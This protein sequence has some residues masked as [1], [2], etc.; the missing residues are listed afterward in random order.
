MSPGTSSCTRSVAHVST[1]DCTFLKLC[2]TCGGIPLEIL[3]DLACILAFSPLTA[4]RLI[5]S[6]H[7]ISSAN[8]KDLIHCLFLSAPTT[9]LCFFVYTNVAL[10]VLCFDC[11]S[12]RSGVL[13]RRQACFLRPRSFWQYLV[14]LICTRHPPPRSITTSTPLVVRGRPTYCIISLSTN[15]AHL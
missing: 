5:C 4:V 9:C 8:T 14:V 3:R 15:H 13:Q 2:T 1:N 12:S 10:R 7:C 11:Y 6:F